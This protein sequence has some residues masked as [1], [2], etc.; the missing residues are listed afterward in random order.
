MN[1]S[2]WD[3]LWD[4]LRDT[5]DILSQEGA[6]AS[7]TLDERTFQLAQRPAYDA[8]AGHGTRNVLTFRLG[9]E[10]YGWPVENVRAIARIS[11]L[12][13]VPSAPPF[14]LGVTSLRGQVL[15]VLDLRTY[16][17]LPPLENK[18]EFMMVIDGAGL[19]I[20]VV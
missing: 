1:P 2:A 16:L 6:D 17:E 8:S 19:E 14:Y 5:A 18:P 3:E 20:G 9:D 12:T 11:H 15:S 7:D 13:H 10:R 4:V